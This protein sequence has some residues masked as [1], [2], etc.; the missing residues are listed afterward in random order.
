MSTINTSIRETATIAGIAAA[1]LTDPAYTAVKFDG[2]GKVVAA[3]AGDRPI[4]IVPAHQ[5]TVAADERID[6]Q[7]KECGLW[8][9]GA[10][11]AAGALLAVGAN[12]TCVTAAE[13]AYIVGVALQD[14]SGSGKIIQVQLANAGAKAPV[15]PAPV[16]DPTILIGTAAAELTTPAN[17]AVKFDGNGKIVAAT[18][19]D[20]PIGIVPTGQATVA[21]DGAIPFKIEGIAQWTAGAVLA[22]GALLA[23]GTGAKAVAATTGAYIVAVALEA[24]TA[25]GD[26]IDV[27]LIN[28][29]AI[30]PAA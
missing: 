11:I 29:G 28:S 4:G 16:V 3:A 19:G 26:V 7:I 8:K 9:T 24:S 23:V 30:V 6:I 5:E 13:G 22:A 25:D 2:S 1:A 12:G 10:A 18:A 14:A 27:Q 17:L 15:T 21:A 20:R